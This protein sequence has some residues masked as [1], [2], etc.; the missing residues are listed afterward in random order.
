MPL[1]LD[2]M[3]KRQTIES[4]CE[5]VESSQRASQARRQDRPHDHARRSARARRGRDRARGRTRRADHRTDSRPRPAG[6]RLPARRSAPM[7]VTGV[8]AG[9]GGHVQVG[10]ADVARDPHGD[11]WSSA[12][13]RTHSGHRGV[14]VRARR[15]RVGL[16]NRQR[17]LDPLS[18][19]RVPIPGRPDEDV[20]VRIVRPRE[21]RPTSLRRGPIRAR[22]MIAHARREFDHPPGVS[23]PESHMGLWVP[24]PLITVLPP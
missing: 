8:A 4:G 21:G 16:F 15:L 18:A 11:S 22:R 23:D 9:V 24:E 20:T 7:R 10:R 2:M 12:R 6:S 19:A 17:R 3:R 13:T 1:T 5:T 14:A